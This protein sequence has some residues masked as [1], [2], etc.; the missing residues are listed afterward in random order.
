MNGERVSGQ[1][2]AAVHGRRVRR[3]G[4]V[5]SDALPRPMRASAGL[6]ASIMR[7]RAAAPPRRRADAPAGVS[8]ARILLAV[9]NARLPMRA[10]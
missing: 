9:S 8:N 1:R 7:C 10:A 3:N 4:F 5:R 6:P 2:G